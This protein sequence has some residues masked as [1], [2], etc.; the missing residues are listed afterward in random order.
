M[1]LNQILHEAEFDF[2]TIDNDDRPG[3][4]FNPVDAQPAISTQQSTGDN[5]PDTITLDIPLFIRIMEWAR[6]D[7]KDDMQLHSV[8]E[9]ITKMSETGRTLTMQD[10]DEIISSCCKDKKIHN[11]S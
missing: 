7:S 5:P 8:T 11:N 3:V 9:K 4:V 10:Y 1:K 6:E 2:N